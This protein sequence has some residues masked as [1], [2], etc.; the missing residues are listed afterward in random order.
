MEGRMRCGDESEVSCVVGKRVATEVR[1]GGR[2][3]NGDE[4]VGSGR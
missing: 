3:R 4:L 1:E 2:E